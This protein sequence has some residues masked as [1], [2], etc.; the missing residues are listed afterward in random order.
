MNLMQNL[1]ILGNRTEK[2]IKTIKHHDQV[3]FI[4]A[5]QGWFN[6]SKCIT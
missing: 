4:A 2:Y 6:I 5:I 1:K 3:V